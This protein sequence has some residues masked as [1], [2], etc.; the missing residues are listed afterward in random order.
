MFE[1]RIHIAIGKKWGRGQPGDSRELLHESKT[2][3]NNYKTDCKEAFF[4]FPE[5]KV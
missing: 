5:E 3:K 4:F 1:V 2:R